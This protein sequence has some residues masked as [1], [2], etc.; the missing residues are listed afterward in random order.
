ML[1]ILST[2]RIGYFQCTLLFFWKKILIR[3]CEAWYRRHRQ[4]LGWKAKFFCP[5][6]TCHSPVAQTMRS[7]TSILRQEIIS[8]VL[9]SSEGFCKTLDHAGVCE[10]ELLMPSARTC[11]VRVG[12]HGFQKPALALPQYAHMPVEVRQLRFLLASALANI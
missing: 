7:Y 3:G 6:S 5:V 11:H 1:C 10:Q 12:V 4:R 2:S 8:P 9:R